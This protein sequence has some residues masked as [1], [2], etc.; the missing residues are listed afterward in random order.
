MIAH[1][2]TGL[3]VTPGDADAAAGAVIRLLADPALRDRLG[4]AALAEAEQT[5]SWSA[6]TQRILDALASRSA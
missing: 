5:Y 6:H 1:E 4:A 3:L 2:E